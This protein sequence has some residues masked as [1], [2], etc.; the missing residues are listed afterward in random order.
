MLVTQ[1]HC[2]ECHQAI[3]RLKENL[4]KQGVPD[5]KIEKARFFTSCSKHEEESSRKRKKE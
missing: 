2:E 4:R 5:E 3:E 1:N